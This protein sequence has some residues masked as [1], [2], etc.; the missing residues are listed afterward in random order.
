MNEQPEKDKPIGLEL[1]A[2]LAEYQALRREIEYRT[3]FQQGV[4]VANVTAFAAV[5]AASFELNNPLLL[6]VV[7]FLS[8]F[9]G[10]YWIDHGLMIDDLGTYIRKT[11]QTKVSEIVGCSEVLLWEKHV[12]SLKKGARTLRFG[13]LVAG[14]FLLPSILSLWL[15]FGTVWEQEDTANKLLWAFGAAFALLW[16]ID[17][18]GGFKSQ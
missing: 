10:F 7:P 12:G 8:S 16:L 11:I 18:L 1:E 9:L 15:S 13:L 5:L 2:T 3:R 17:E 14:L 6:L 4:V